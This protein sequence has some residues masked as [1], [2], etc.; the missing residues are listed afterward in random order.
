MEF[1]SHSRIRFSLADAAFRNGGALTTFL[2]S[3]LN[4]RY[5]GVFLMSAFFFLYLLVWSWV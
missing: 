1:D 5:S 2:R 4:L 3:F